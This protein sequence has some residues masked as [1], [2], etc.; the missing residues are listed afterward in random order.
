LGRLESVMRLAAFALSIVVTGAVAYCIFYYRVELGLVN[1]LNVPETTGTAGANQ[2]QTNATQPAA[3]PNWQMVDRSNDGFRIEM[4]GDVSEGHAPAFTGRGA[5]VE[6]PMIEASPHPENQFAVAWDEDP[7]VER[8]AGEA[9]EKTFDLAQAGALARTRAALAGER[10]SNAGGYPERDFTG[11]TYDGGVL[12]VRMVL[13]GRQLY[14]LI[15]TSPSA[16][17]EHD[18]DVD[19]FFSSFRLTV[20]S[21]AN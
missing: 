5:Q 9:A 17:A 20:T 8:A 7:P 16:S 15:V 4:P 11:R 19:R 21:R 3:A 1:K 12:S 18:A 14:T 2:G 6:I 13:A 10:K